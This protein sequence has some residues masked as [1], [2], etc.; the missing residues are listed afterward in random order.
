MTDIIPSANKSLDY[1][2][3]LIALK[4][5][6]FKRNGIIPFPEVSRVLSWYRFGKKD[7]DILL[8]EFERLELI[9]VVPYHGIR[10][11]QNGQEVGV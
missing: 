11:L 8:Y 1:T 4:T 9:E 3:F 10:L 5:R 2:K 6:A 7:Q